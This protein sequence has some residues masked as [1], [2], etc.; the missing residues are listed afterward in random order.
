MSRSR[1][2]TA[3]GVSA[4]LALTLAAPIAAV[5]A[6]AESVD[7]IDYLAAT[8]GLPHDHIVETVTYERFE[9]L[10]NQEGS[11]V[12]LLGGPAE[13]SEEIVE[14][15]AAAKAAGVP[16]VYNFDPVLD[17][18]SGLDADES[19]DIRS[20]EVVKRAGT[21]TR[22]V[23]LVSI[24]WDNLADNY[25]NKDTDAS[26]QFTGD[27]ASDPV[28]F[29]YN[30]DRV[31]EAG[32]LDVED[33]IISAVG[34]FTGEDAAGYRAALDAALDLPA[35]LEYGE[36]TQF[37]FYSEQSNSR[38]AAQYPNAETHGG[39]IFDE[40]DAEGFTLQSITY[41]ELE[42]LLESDGKFLIF[43]GG[44]WC[45][46]TRAVIK[47]INAEAKEQGI[48]VVYQFDLRLDGFSSDTLHIRDTNSYFADRYGQL[49][50][51]YLPNLVTQYR[52][53]KSAGQRVDYYADGDR[54]NELTAAQ[55]LQV[56][57]IIEY[58]KSNVDALGQSAPVVHEWIKDN[59]DGTYREFMTEWWYTLGLRG[60]R[61]TIEAA[62][63]DIAFAAEAVAAIEPFFTAVTSGAATAPKHADVPF[64]AVTSVSE[65]SVTVN[66]QA[67]RVNGSA[68]T[69]YKVT[70]GNPAVATADAPADAT[71]YTFTNV[72][73]GEYTATVAAVTGVGTTA[74]SD[75]SNTVTVVAAQ[76]P[77]PGE[78]PGPTQ[79]NQPA[80]P[81]PQ[82]KQPAATSAKKAKTRITVK[83]PKQV[84]ASKR[85]KV[86]VT[87]NVVGAKTKAKGKVVIRVG[88]KKV[89]TAKVKKGKAT[90]A[91]KKLRGVK[92][93]KRGVAKLQV[94]YQGN[95][96]FAK[97]KKNAKIRVVR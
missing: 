75:A 28:V 79:P 72:P 65:Q 8:Y 25:L 1:K 12:F 62:A 45:H 32:D 22:P 15:N 84:K 34:Q 46:N 9:Y 23:E 56:P 16:A 49:A 70:L 54:N 35:G 95:K 89:G 51:E 80:Q 41:P 20:S 73:G 92:L 4:A 66:W 7:T 13:I 82:V 19:F 10:L 67:P 91:L 68:I 83:A 44:T 59:N 39:P 42:Y 97:S 87:V 81:T 11:F 6:P 29:V 77:G 85:A 30:K 71:S 21:A 50:N 52:L 43:F 48:D 76:T 47:Q 90:V 18:R 37:E 74:A 88:K 93:T 53:D 58:D 94:T 17:G 5:A 38:H 63:G 27:P 86:R 2:L 36:S 57:Y 3:A 60:G 14:V 55:K 31:I 33:R 78:N 24:L 40:S 61:A 96:N 26:Q 69:G 64:P